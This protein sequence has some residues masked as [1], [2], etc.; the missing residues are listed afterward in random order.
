M[1]FQQVKRSTKNILRKESI[2]NWIVKSALGLIG[3]LF[4]FGVSQST[5]TQAAADTGE[6]PSSSEIAPET[7]TNENEPTGEISGNWGVDWKF[8]DGT[9][10]ISGGKLNNT[11]YYGYD[12][13]RN[14]KQWENLKLPEVTKI[15]ITG[16]ITAGEDISGLFKEFVNVTE[17]DGLDKLD[18]SNVTDMS[19]AFANCNNLTAINVSNFQ[20]DKVTDFS[21]MFL[22]NHELTGIDLS[23]WKWSAGMNFKSMFESCEKLGTI[24]LPTGLSSGSSD[25]DFSRM[26]Y[27]DNSVESLNLSGLDMSKTDKVNELLNLAGS[28]STLTLS[29]KNNLTNAELNPNFTTDGDATQGIA[30]WKK[31]ND[32]DVNASNKELME[33]YDGKDK[34]DSE[35]AKWTWNELPYM[36]FTVRYVDEDDGSLITTRE[37]TSSDKVL[38]F[39]E[40]KPAALIAIGSTGSGHAIQFEPEPVTLTKDIDGKSINVKIPKAAIKFVVYE[41]GKRVPSDIIMSNDNIVDGKV[42]FKGQLN[43]LKNKK[44]ILADSDTFDKSKSYFVFFGNPTNITEE[45]LTK[46]ELTDYSSYSDIIQVLANSLVDENGKIP[47]SFEG[48]KVDFYAVYEPEKNTNSGGGSSTGGSSTT[49]VNREVKAIEEKIGT[50]NNNPDVQLYDDNGDIVKDRKLAPSSDWYTDN[51]MTLKGVKYYRVAT[52]LWAKADD[53]YIYYPST[54]NVLVNKGSIARLVTSQG[55]DVT[56]RALQ[57][58]SGWY[59]DRYTYINGEKYYRVATNEFVSVDKVQEY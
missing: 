34:K 28:I 52:D 44:L 3:G 37:I 27:Y 15:E 6:Q 40:F 12:D 14:T 16:N 51:L 18:T 41:N 33:M 17:I 49:T 38:P 55:K 45:L 10:Q 53:I 11:H 31:N 50:H 21:N 20:T 22:Q 42:D 32:S 25:S 8:S 30:G 5:V 23:N 46:M 4:L 19:Y 7:V 56:D 9:L 26:F 43:V 58:G 54:A 36:N 35:V 48:G 2:K 59:T 39:S 29:S 24:D 57:G 13:E 1:R 47:T